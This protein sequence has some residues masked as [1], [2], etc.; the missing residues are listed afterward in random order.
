MGNCSVIIMVACVCMWSVSIMLCFSCCY[1]H[2]VCPLLLAGGDVYVEA[3]VPALDPPLDPPP[4][5]LP[6]N[7]P[8]A[9]SE[10]ALLLSALLAVDLLLALELHGSSA[11]VI[12][13]LVVH[14]YEQC[15]NYSYKLY[16]P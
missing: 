14:Q 1:F 5:P 2:G 10:P 13:T 16:T 8:L 15:Q 11:I 6:D 7:L 4:L 9:L 12:I 3:L